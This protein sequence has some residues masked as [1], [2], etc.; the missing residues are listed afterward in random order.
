ML[1]KYQEMLEELKKQSRGP[2]IL[3][4]MKKTLKIMKGELEDVRVFN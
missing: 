1:E 3:A 4:E 2:A